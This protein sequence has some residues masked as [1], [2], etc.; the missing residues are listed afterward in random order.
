MFHRFFFFL[1]VSSL[2]AGPAYADA[3]T[4]MNYPGECLDQSYMALGIPQKKIARQKTSFKC[5]SAVFTYTD[6]LTSPIT[7]RFYDSA[8]GPDYLLEFDGAMDHDGHTIYIQK[9]YG[10]NEKPIEAEYTYCNVVLIGK[11]LD[12]MIC[13]VRVKGDEQIPSLL[14]GFQAKPVK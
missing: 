3:D 1:I 2:F 6:S 4:A 14:I 9:I 5:D 11:Y 8:S 12:G 13:A 10:P 7:I